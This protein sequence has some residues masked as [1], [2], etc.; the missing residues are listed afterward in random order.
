M[1]PA[2][3]GPGQALG[4]RVF[5]SSKNAE[6][7]GAFFTCGQECKARRGTSSTTSLSTTKAV[8]LRHSCI[9]HHNLAMLMPVLVAAKADY[10]TAE[11]GPADYQCGDDGNGPQFFLGGLCIGYVRVQGVG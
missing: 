2:V 11:L 1:H 10:C 3:Q 6:F 7:S 9:H 8:V 5:A 4:I